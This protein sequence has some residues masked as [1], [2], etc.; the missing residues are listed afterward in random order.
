MPASQELHKPR[1]EAAGGPLKASQG[2]G[3]RPE[4]MA[5]SQEKTGTSTQAALSQANSA[6]TSHL[7]N[8]EVVLIRRGVEHIYK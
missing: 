2:K 5:M 4:S 7:S 8:P 6:V 1:G 3:T